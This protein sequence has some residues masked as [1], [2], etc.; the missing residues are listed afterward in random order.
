METIPDYLSIPANELG[1]GTPVKVRILGDL[2]S[3]GRDLAQAMFDE[4]LAGEQSGRGVTMIVPVGP[5]D[6]FPI[7][8]QRLNERRVSCRHAVFINMDEYLTDDDRWISAGHPLS[9]RK[10]PNNVSASGNSI[11][12]RA[13][14]QPEKNNI[15][16]ASVRPTLK[17]KPA[18]VARKCVGNNSGK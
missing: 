13:L 5:V 14:S 16:A 10:N 12:G 3:L 4:I 6:Q 8:A 9:F 17:Q 18:P 15:V 7:L 2:A 1:K 11:P